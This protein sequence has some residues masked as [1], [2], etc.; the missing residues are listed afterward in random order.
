M[1]GL[2]PMLPVSLHL[3]EH[4]TTGH[5][6]LASADPDDLPLVDPGLLRDPDDVR[7][8]VDGIGLVDRLTSH[9]ALAAFYGP[10]LTPESPARW[11]EHVLTSYDTYHHGVG[12]CRIGP[13]GDPGAVVDP[14]LRVH[15]IDNLRVADAS[16]LPTVP[17]ANTNLAAIMV[18]E[19][20]AREIARA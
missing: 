6:S 2:P 11:E 18:G 1:P 15:G 8:L 10:L 4:R 16:V 7:A 14:R 12:T 20:A 13:D 5:V 3:L 19:I 17:H 9:P